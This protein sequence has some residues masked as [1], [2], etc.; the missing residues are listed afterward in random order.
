[1][2]DIERD[3]TQIRAAADQRAGSERAA[4]A[5]RRA[6]GGAARSEQ[7]RCPAPTGIPG[8]IFR[9]IVQLCLVAA[10]L[11]V[12][13]AASR[14]ENNFNYRRHHRSGGAVRRHLHLHAAGAGDPAGSGHG[15]RAG[16]RRCARQVL[17]G[18]RARL[19]SFLD[20]A[21]TYLVFFK[22]AQSRAGRAGGPTGAASPRRSWPPS[23]WAPCS[24]AP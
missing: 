19:S 21:P 5:G 18:H 6:G 13:L 17:L 10:S 20:N 14:D 12:R 24:W 9:E 4:A 1:M 16:P 2:A 15:D 7:G 23:A 8:C 3:I 11:L 22:T